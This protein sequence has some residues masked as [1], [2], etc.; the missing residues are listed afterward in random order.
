MS[1]TKTINLSTNDSIQGEALLGIS[2]GP[3]SRLKGMHAKLNPHNLLSNMA[4][5]P[6][7]ANK[8][9]ATNSNFY[10]YE[11]VAMLFWSRCG[12]DLLTSTECVFGNS[13]KAIGSER[14]WSDLAFLF[15]DDKLQPYCVEAFQTMIHNDP[16]KILDLWQAQLI[17][18]ESLSEVVL[19][20]LN[21]QRY[22]TSGRIKKQMML[23]GLNAIRV[24]Q[25]LSGRTIW[26]SGQYF[27]TRS[28]GQHIVLNLNFPCTW[29]KKPVKEE[30]HDS[31]GDIFKLSAAFVNFSDGRK[32]SAAIPIMQ[33]RMANMF[34][35]VFRGAAF[36]ATVHLTEDGLVTL[37]SNTIESTVSDFGIENPIANTNLDFLVWNCKLRP[38]GEEKWKLTFECVKMNEL[39]ILTIIPFNPFIEPNRRYIKQRVS[40]NCLVGYKNAYKLSWLNRLPMFAGPLKNS[41]MEPMDRALKLNGLFQRKKRGYDIKSEPLNDE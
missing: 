17:K 25:A 20:L 41:R 28:T 32:G 15:Y 29:D 1:E 10:S 27:V 7:L 26:R 12:F 31:S 8:T 3:F 16:T 14:P 24:T 30:V 40:P 13:E 18:A 22:V 38:R 23:T 33:P 34:P 4:D 19:L 9:A 21:V 39:T 5:E 36:Y 35:Y 2:H 6:W 11:N 37:D